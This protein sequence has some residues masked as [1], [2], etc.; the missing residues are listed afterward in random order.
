MG[1]LIDWVAKQPWSDGRVG[2][3]GVSYEGTTALLA[4]ASHHPAL[5]A[6]L[7][8]EI[9]WDLVDELLAPGGVRNLSFSKAWGESVSAL[10]RNQY[11]PLFPASGKW[12]VDGVHRS[13][14]DKDGKRLAAIVAGRKV[15]DIA[16]QVS[17]VRSGRD[18]FGA[19]GPRPHR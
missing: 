19:G 13:A 3:T 2:A 6:V 1:D 14:D 4:A 18:A 12:I 8:R 9:E 17:D 11:P 7:A 10:D 16:A 5:K 15:A